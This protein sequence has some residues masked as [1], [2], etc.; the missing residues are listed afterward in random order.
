MP[1]GMSYAGRKV[2]KKELRDAEGSGAATGRVND[3][4]STVLKVEKATLP[5]APRRRS[6]DGFSPRGKALNAKNRFA[7]FP[8][9]GDG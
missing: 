5:R 8:R 6:F 3:R 2:E 9:C 4:W 1:K 7:A